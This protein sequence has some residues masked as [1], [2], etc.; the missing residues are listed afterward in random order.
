MW[1]AASADETD[2]VCA[3]RS[4]GTLAATDE[5]A[6]S[7]HQQLQG[8]DRNAA[9]SR[10]KEANQ[11]SRVSRNVLIDGKYQ[12][13]ENL[14]SVVGLGGLSGRTDPYFCELYP[15]CAFKALEGAAGRDHLGI[16]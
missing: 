12:R 11:P 6:Q 2:A 16:F 15:V 7:H 13:V 4:R 14:I 8:M 1:F 10:R 9:R 5:R 3:G